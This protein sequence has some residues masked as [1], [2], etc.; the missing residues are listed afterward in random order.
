M[1]TWKRCGPCSLNADVNAHG[2]VALMM[3]QYDHLEVVQALLAA[4]ADVN[5]KECR[6]VDTALMWASA[7]GHVDVVRALLAANAD[8]N[9]KDA[10]WTHGV[11]DCLELGTMGSSTASGGFVLSKRQIGHPNCADLRGRPCVVTQSY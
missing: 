2:D 4:N 5:A 11:G 10:R 7:N 3:P 9:A 1:A 8:V 6:M